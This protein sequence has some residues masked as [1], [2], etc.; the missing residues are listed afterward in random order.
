MFITTVLFL[1]NLNHWLFW[2]KWG[3]SGGIPPQKIL[4]FRCL[5]MLFSLFSRQYFGPKT[6][7]IKTVLTIFYVYYNRSFPQNLNLWLLEKSEIINLQMLIKK[8]YIQCFKFKFSFWKNM[9][10]NVCFGFFGTDAILE[11]VKAWDLVLW[12]CPR[13]STTLRSASTFCTSTERLKRLNSWNVP[14]LRLGRLSLMFYNYF[15]RIFSLF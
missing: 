1:K 14:L 7:K 12:K 3:G 11:H 2:K 4:R 15:C 8:K 6:I 5:E 10:S 9:L 13:R